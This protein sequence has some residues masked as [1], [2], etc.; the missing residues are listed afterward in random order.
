MAKKESLAEFTK[1]AEAVLRRLR[2]FS[3]PDGKRVVKELLQQKT[4]VSQGIRSKRISEGA[5]IFFEYDPLDKTQVCDYIPL[6]IILKVSRSHVLG[7]NLHWI[8]MKKRAQ[9]LSAISYY[10]YLHNGSFS[11]EKYMFSYKFLKVFLKNPAYRKCVRLYI[12]KRMS[13]D[14]VI[15][16]PKYILDVARLKLEHFK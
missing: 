10:N 6:S 11:P 12:R 7:C 4:S 13:R 15:I 1:K 2:S 8:D 9:L 3:I 5:I 16:D 14:C